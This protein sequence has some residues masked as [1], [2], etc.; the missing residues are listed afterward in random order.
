KPRARPLDQ[1]VHGDRRAVHHGADLAQIDTVLVGQTR[2]AGAD[3]LGELVRSRRDLQAGELAA[4][5]VEEG[6]VGEGAADVDPKPV[7]RHRWRN[8]A[9][10]AVPRQDIATA[11]LLAP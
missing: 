7:P 2:Q 3:R 4:L 11:W 9:A 1:G 5:R 6:E 10:S 8:C